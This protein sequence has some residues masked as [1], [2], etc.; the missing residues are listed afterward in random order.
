MYRR[1]LRFILGDDLTKYDLP[2]WRSFFD[3]RVS[4][5][6]GQQ[7]ASSYI[8]YIDR[9]SSIGVAPIF[10]FSH[11]ADLVGV[12]Y[13]LMAAMA[14]E[15]HEFYRTFSLQ[16]RSGGIRHIDV[17]R[18]ALLV[19]QRWILKE[20]LSSLNVSD[21]AHGFIKG[22]SIITNARAHAKSR[23]LLKVDIKDFFPSIQFDKVLKVFESVGYPRNVS[24]AL[25]RFSTKNSCLP[26]GAATSPSLSNLVCRDLD[27]AMEAIAKE[28]GLIYTRYADDLV[29]SGEKILDSMKI[30]VGKIALEFGF[31]L[32]DKKTV[33]AREGH[34]KIVT[35]ISISSGDLKLPRSYLRELRKQ[36]H[37]VTVRGVT[38]HERATQ[39]YDPLLLDRLLG[40]VSFWLQVSPDS[41]VAQDAHRKLRAYVREFDTRPL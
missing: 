39:N 38:A 10:E 27:I 34:R 6:R 17:P 36:I 26:Q 32:N 12:D 24:W 20:I 25:A 11:L 18:P 8:Q 29:F 40:M 3:A 16:K 21:A 30:F 41:T 4:G 1:C 5:L 37:Y 23:E 2:L 9:L 33:V 35:G 15:P 28:N 22:R 31:I 19:V 14:H 7:L 13:R